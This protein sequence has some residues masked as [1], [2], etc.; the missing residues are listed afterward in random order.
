MYVMAAAY[1]AQQVAQSETADKV[2][3]LINNKLDEYIKDVKTSVKE[4]S[5]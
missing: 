2:V 4:K 5:K 1:G 3:T